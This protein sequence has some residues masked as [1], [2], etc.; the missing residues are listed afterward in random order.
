M[1]HT[2]ASRYPFPI[3]FDEESL[4]KMVENAVDWAHGHGLV[5]RTADHKDRSD[6]CQ[7]APFTLLP[8]PFPNRLF[9]EAVNIQ[10]AINLLYFRISS[11]YEFLV[12]AHAEVIKTDDFTRHFV[13]ILKHIHKVGLKQTKTLLIQRADY[14]CDEQVVGSNDFRLRQ[15]EVN[16]IAASMG[17]LGEMTS[18]LHRRTLQDLG[19]SDEIIDNYLPPSNQPI[20]TIAE[21]IF[22]AWLG[23]DVGDV[24]S[25]I[26]FVVEDVNQ[27]QL[28]QRHV[29]Y[30]IDKLSAR[31]AKCVRLTLTE[32]AH[33]L[34]LGGTSGYELLLDKN[35]C[36]TI[37]YFRAGYS[38]S[39]YPS[40][41]E[42]NARLQI[43]LSTAVKCPWIGLQL[44]NTKKIQQ[45]LAEEG[46]L[47]KFL[48]EAKSDCV[49]IRATFAGLWGLENDD[50]STQEIVKKAIEHPERFVLK[51]QLEGGGGNYYGDEVSTKLKRMN[52][53]ERAAH[54]LMERIRP[55]VVKN[56]LIR[57][58][59]SVELSNIVGE[60]GVYGCLY[61]EMKMKGCKDE[62]IM[63]NISKGHIIRSKCEHVDKGGV[64]IG[65][66][67][68]DSPLLI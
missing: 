8:S 48:A 59:E 30:R 3:K 21:G 67:V 65:A 58:F 53:S 26:L 44:A 51:P 1:D 49:R 7:T 45:V 43:E 6:I 60:L 33:R 38:P 13:E 61:G 19:V 46:Q 35:E 5:M 36:I 24:K 34:T 2:C 56:Y 66:A 23:L 28:D 11:D 15:V 40:E 42:W 64:A 32:C 27:N 29:E 17:W 9:Q 10:Q 50:V 41:L 47:E 37:V 31:R 68:I 63:M 14:M 12:N 62:R 55:M 39:N 22:D 4:N 25:L 16:N 18:C 54:I 57:P 20:D 52:L